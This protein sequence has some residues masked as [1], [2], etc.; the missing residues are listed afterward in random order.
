M[1]GEA[2]RKIGSLKKF[3]EN[4]SVTVHHLGTI[5]DANGLHTIKDD[6]KKHYN[7]ICHA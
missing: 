4:S 5:F 7:P 1:L 3:A 2:P 6:S